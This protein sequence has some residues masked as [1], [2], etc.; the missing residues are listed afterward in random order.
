MSKDDFQL[1]KDIFNLKSGTIEDGKETYKTVYNDKRIV[2]TF[3][4]NNTP[5]KRYNIEVQ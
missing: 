1:L 2:L 5:S 4:P 3:N